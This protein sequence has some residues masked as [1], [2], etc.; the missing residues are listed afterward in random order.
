MKPLLAL[1][2]LLSLFALAPSCNTVDCVTGKPTPPAQA[3]HNAY[4]TAAAN[5]GSVGQVC[6][7]SPAPTSKAQALGNPTSWCEPDP[8]DDACAACIAAQC[9]AIITDTCR[10]DGGA[11]DPATCVAIPTVN[12]CITNNCAACS[13][14]Q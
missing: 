13:A 1:L 2:A 3:Y 6:F 11:S 4:T 10:T 5:E 7:E 12:A 9:C 14:P 8:T